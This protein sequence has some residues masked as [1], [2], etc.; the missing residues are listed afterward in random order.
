MIDAKEKPPLSVG[1]AL[2]AVMFGCLGLVQLLHRAYLDASIWL[3]LA[4]ALV[5]FGHESRAW[6]RIPEW[7]K[8]L[9]CVLG[10]AA[11]ALFVTRV[12]LDLAN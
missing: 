5:S 12:M 7:R 9:G 11:A 4:L 6:S 1:N 2:V 3:A 8:A 10:A